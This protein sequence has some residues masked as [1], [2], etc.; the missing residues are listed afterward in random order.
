M[1]SLFWISAI[2]RRWAVLAG[3]V[4]A[5]AVLACAFA[6]HDPAPRMAQGQDKVE[7]IAAFLALGALFGWRAS[8]WTLAGVGL[9]LAGL[10]V[11][12]ETFQAL[13]TATREPSVADAAASLAGGGA[14]LLLAAWLNAGRNDPN[15]RAD[16]IPLERRF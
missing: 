3:W 13:F 16:P 11:G 4:L 8:G 9:C 12:I 7:H 10:A 5:A 1:R 2:R 14:G 6:P 15:V